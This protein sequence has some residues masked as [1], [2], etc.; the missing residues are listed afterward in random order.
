MKTLDTW[1]GV[2][3]P[4][5]RAGVG[6]PCVSMSG[7]VNRIAGHP[8][9]MTAVLV[10][11]QAERDR[12]K[13]ERDRLADENERLRAGKPRNGSPWPS[14]RQIS[15]AAQCLADRRTVIAH[16]TRL[17]SMIDPP[18]EPRP[19]TDEEVVLHV[20][21]SLRGDRTPLTEDERA[22][23]A[24]PAPPTKPCPYGDPT[25]PCQDGDPCHYEDHEGTPAMFAPPTTPEDDRG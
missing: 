16:S 19:M 20:L 23:L 21:W 3:C 24:V 17:N 5:C 15:D 2:L 22:A 13:D 18:P 7:R 11:L 14:P 6:R 1:S 10:A 8:Q 12:Y 4:V 25:C 9:R